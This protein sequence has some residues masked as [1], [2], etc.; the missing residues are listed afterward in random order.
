M[1]STVMVPRQP[2]SVRS[3]AVEDFKP[4]STA[5]TLPMR[6]DIDAGQVGQL[7]PSFWGQMASKKQLCK[8]FPHGQWLWA[9]V[10]KLLLSFDITSCPGNCV[11]QLCCEFSYVAILWSVS[12]QNKQTKKCQ[13]PKIVEIF[14]INRLSMLKEWGFLLNE[15]VQ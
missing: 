3:L 5:M 14:K 15:N 2:I 10:Y 12:I 4:V 7:S 11:A 8:N 6:F 13:I 1:L 9:I